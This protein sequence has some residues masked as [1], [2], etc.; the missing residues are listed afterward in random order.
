[1]TINRRQFLGAAGVAAAAVTTQ[2]GCAPKSG[3]SPTLSDL[4]TIRDQY[5]RAT[6]QV[7]LDCAAHCPLLRAI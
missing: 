7:Y 2:T 3:A 1:M 4:A 5:P 6:Q